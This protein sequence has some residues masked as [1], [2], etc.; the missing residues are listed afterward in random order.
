M[1]LD[2]SKTLKNM[3]GFTEAA[4]RFKETNN[5]CE[6]PPNLHPKSRYMKFWAEERRRSIYGLDL[7]YDKIPGYFY[8]YLN[9]C[10]I[11]LVKETIET[12]G[13][14]MVQAERVSSF[15]HVWDGDYHY[16]NYLDEAEK[17][18][19]HAV[20]LK[21]RGRG[22]LQPYSEIIKT[23]YGNTTIGEIK[24][25]DEIIGSDGKFYNVVEKYEKGEQDV[26]EV[27]FN[28][29]R[30]VRCGKE[31]LWL[32]YDKTQRKKRNLVYSTEYMMNKGL[33]YKTGQGQK[34]YK[35]YV[36]DSDV[37][38]YGYKELPTPAYTL[39]ALL[40]DGSLLTGSIKIASSDKEILERI[41]N[42][43]GSE[44]SLIY[45]DTTTNNYRIITKKEFIQKN[46]YIRVNQLKTDIIK[47]GI[48]VS[49]KFK[50]IPDIYKYSS[51]EQRMNLVRG[52]L[53][54]D[55]YISETGGIEFV[56][57]NKK[58]CDD[59]MDVLRS[60]GISCR[61]GED[62]RTGQ[63]HKYPS[64]AVGIRSLTYRI[65]IRTNK[66]VF[67]LSRKLNRIKNIKRFERSPIISITKLSYTENSAC[68]YVDSPD[69]TYLTT[70]Y[71]VTHNSFKG[72][73][74]LNRNYFL[75]PRSKSYAFAEE[76]EYLISDGVLN[77][78]WDMMNFIDTNTAWMKR[79]QFKN[80]D[81]HKR[82]SYEKNIG[83]V[84][85]ESGYLSEII[86]VSFKNNP[87][88]AHPYSSQVVTPD[89]IKT[90][91]EIEV[92]SKL[93]GRDGNIINVIETHE[94]GVQ[95]VYEITFNDGR[96]VKCSDAHEWEI[97][98]WFVKNGKAY[99]EPR[100]YET[101]ELIRF[102]EMKSLRC[103]S[104][105][106]KI[107]EAVDFSHIEV[108]IDPYTL[109]LMLGDGSLGKSNDSRTD[110]TM[111]H[112]DINQLVEFIP[113]KIR[114]ENWGGDIRNTIF[115]KDCRKILKELNLFDK[116]SGDKFIPDLYKFNTI[117][118]RLDIV[119]GLLDTDGSVTTDF[120][121]IEYCSKS[122]QLAEDFVWIV[123]SLGI[124]ATIKEK[125]FK[126]TTYY[127]C[128]IYCKHDEIRLFNLIRKKDKLKVKKKNR[129]ALNKREFITIEKIEKVGKESIKCVTVDSKDTMYIIE[130]FIPTFNSRGKRG[131]LILWEE[132]GKFPSLLQ[133]WQI[134]RSSV[135]QGNKVFG[136]MVSFGTGGTEGA[137]YEGL[138]ELFDNPMGYNIFPVTNIWSE[139]GKGKECGFFVPEYLNREGHYDKDGNSDTLEA[140]KEEIKNRE[141][142]KMHTSDK[143]SYSRY[144]A[145]KP[146]TP[147]EATLRISGN[148]FPELDLKERLAYI[149]THDEAKN[150]GQIGMLKRDD[151]GLPKWKG[152]PTLQPCSFPVNAKDNGEGAI[153]IWEHPSKEGIP[154]GLYIAGMD[155]YD[156]DEST[157]TSLG[158]IF[159]YKRLYTMESW[160]ETIVAEYTGR[161]KSAE[162][163]YEN[164]RR[165]LEY[166]NAVCL[167]ENQNPGFKTYMEKVGSLHLLKP[168]PGILK[169]I[170]KDTRVDRTYGVHM[171]INV[172]NY[173]EILIR[174]WLTEEYSPGKRNLNKIYS[175]PLLKEL[176]AYNKDGNYDRIIG[177]GLCLL[178]NAE[179][180]RV[181][182]DKVNDQ[183]YEDF[184][185]RTLF[186]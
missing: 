54:T 139:Y 145:E 115:I 48:N 27:E 46:G 128:Y 45:D 77:K 19:K 172:K 148:I 175:I 41:Q 29:G 78:A 152:D 166:Y 121:V 53:D 4:L 157:T 42:E 144:I 7:G 20:V 80:T 146:F 52:L 56:G 39:G 159:I 66:P 185:E 6:Y 171:T 160:Y 34:S 113:Y 162:E 83:G 64:G 31:H 99:L 43:V 58:L 137:S 9:Y 10:P 24:P 70:D 111:K 74:M 51:V 142:V 186:V 13:G 155:S 181:H 147:E 165:L 149:E 26:Y 100:K 106:V 40:G 140:K 15:P 183:I 123:R 108:P 132:S 173:I 35:F 114:N 89:G 95:D 135:E 102:L 12:E 109:G 88:K 81:M 1:T 125:T 76:K 98:R 134:A 14:G 167:Y 11:E 133:G 103:N 75:I 164:A 25:G 96:K 176:I 127:R 110:I 5:Y 59:L 158:S 151:D 184:F 57:V 71:V 170:I 118:V 179:N 90:W 107:G 104:L 180:Y 62:N 174:D 101:T 55:G 37:I 105:K 122:K 182:L 61:I 126:G 129:Y 60:L 18:G 65:Y 124:G 143:N 154:H 33:F 156:F 84:K 138:I 82:A 50:F 38:E 119:N 47:L 22:F 169:N 153:V 49:C 93:Y 94:F 69:H 130:D 28:D 67:S 68:L 87:Q 178:H 32:I 30:K 3:S 2:Y 36:Q 97:W 21:T 91:Q 8:F 131:K 136:L 72:G 79:R 44:Y 168:Q 85:T 177:F 63:L 163:F 120:G 86:G 16:F 116:R 117:K 150:L 112:A 23:P 141:L 92:G 73:S 17:A 161:A